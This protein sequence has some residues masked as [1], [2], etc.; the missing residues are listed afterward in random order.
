MEQTIVS[1]H[2]ESYS[3]YFII[4][5]KNPIF[6][7]CKRCTEIAPTRMPSGQAGPTDI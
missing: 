4:Y 7:Q 2:I 6:H 5:K 3:L 1:Y